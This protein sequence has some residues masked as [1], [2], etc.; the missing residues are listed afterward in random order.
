MSTC[1][2]E[3]STLYALI[4]RMLEDWL[5][6]LRL[7]LGRRI[8]YDAQRKIVQVS[9]TELWKGPCSAQELEAMQFVC[10]HC[11]ASVVRIPRVRRAYR[12]R[13]EGLFIAMDFI[14]GPTLE[15]L[16]PALSEGEK[17][18]A[19]QDIW[20]QVRQLRT[21]PAPEDFV[22][23]SARSGSGVR[24]G[25]LLQDH[26]VGPFTHLEEF[27]SLLRENPNVAEFAHFWDDDERKP[28]HSRTVFAHADLSP[29]NIIRA[30]D[31]AL[32]I[33]DW[34]F[35]GWWPAYWECVKWH[36]ADFPPCQGWTELMDE[37][38]GIGS[39]G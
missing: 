20:S 7:R 27:E 15:R 14:A 1:L 37:V 36:F 19:V 30:K 17:R 12:R 29:R 13:K 38:S 18:S 28:A 16:W 11:P 3:M 22:V 25:A 8:K 10:A 24:D 6:P 5:F 4:K 34:E 26:A 32:F 9:P 39:W 23:G 31:G 21:L 2:P 33:I 35:G